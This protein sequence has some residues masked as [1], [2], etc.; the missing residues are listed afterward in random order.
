MRCVYVPLLLLVLAGCG[1]GQAKAP[2]GTQTSGTLTAQLKPDPDPP[3]VGHDTSFVVTLTD[4][5][6]PVAGATVVIDLSFK[7]LNQ[8]GPSGTCTEGAPGRY[9]V[10]DLSTGMN[11]RW[12]AA[13]TVSRGN[14]PDAK[15]TF[16][17]FVHK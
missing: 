13:V 16:P 15:F 7:S 8:K 3:Q 6:Q 10:R 2:P 9:E 5:G 14:L 4:A 11:G 1:G 17:F 12:E